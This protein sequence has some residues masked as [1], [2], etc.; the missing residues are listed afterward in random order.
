MHGRRVL[1]Q[2]CSCLSSWFPCPVLSLSLAAASTCAA[3]SVLLGEDDLVRTLDR[4]P[5]CRLLQMYE[6]Q[7]VVLLQQRIVNISPTARIQVAMNL[8]I[9]MLDPSIFT[10]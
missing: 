2:R 9:I 1:R 4:E 5:T 6:G 7:M 10:N 8:C 3:P